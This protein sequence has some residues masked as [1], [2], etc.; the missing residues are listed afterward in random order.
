MSL[1]KLGNAP[2]GAYTVRIMAQHAIGLIETDT[3]VSAIVGADAAA[4][5]AQVTLVAAELNDGGLVTVRLEGELADVQVA[6]EAAV[7][8][9]RQL[10]QTVT[11]HVIARPSEELAPL[12]QPTGFVELAHR[13]HEAVRRKPA[14]QARPQ[15]KPV[16]AK[17]RPSL[18]SPPQPK[19]ADTEVVKPAPVPAPE[20]DTRVA[21]AEAKPVTTPAGIPDW[22]EIE[23][24]PVVKL[25]RFARTVKGLP[26]QGRQISM[27][28][29][30]QL[31]AVL[32]KHLNP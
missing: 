22:A 4:K 23:R 11:T 8:A 31:L 19:P 13:K 30:T 7:T 1:I 12:L 16:T 25:R 10:R 26:I 9:I 18:V 21:E 2:M 14:T 17:S 27:A 5:N 15:P 6:V 32:R 28:N 20:P 29:K 3:L 24:M